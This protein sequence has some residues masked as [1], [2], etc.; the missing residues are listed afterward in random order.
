MAGPAE[1]ERR[2][3]SI[4]VRVAEGGD[5][6]VRQ[7]FLAIDQAVVTST[8]VDKGTARSNWLPGFDDPIDGEREA[9]VPGDK[10]STAAANTQ[11]A[12]DEAKGV[13]DRYDGGTHRSLHLTNNLPYIGELNRGTST[14]APELFV[15]TAVAEGASSVRGARVLD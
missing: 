14:Q 1:F 9:F 11:A 8:P 4:G 15:E 2:I 6:V 13:A 3:Q 10:G 12:L 7:A 5:R